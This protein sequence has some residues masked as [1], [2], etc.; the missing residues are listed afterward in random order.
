MGNL[1]PELRTPGAG[2]PAPMPPGCSPLG[3]A[4]RGAFAEEAAAQDDGDNCNVAF[5]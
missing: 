4:R 5:G 1:V 2:C 3:P